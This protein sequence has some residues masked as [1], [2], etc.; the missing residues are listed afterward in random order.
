MSSVG[1][2]AVRNKGGRVKGQFR[3]GES[4]EAP[5][6]MPSSVLPASHCAHSQDRA[7]GV[8]ASRAGGVLGRERRAGLRAGVTHPSGRSP[9]SEPT[10]RQARRL[11]LR[12][13]ALLESTA[14]D[15]LETIP[16]SLTSQLGQNTSLPSLRILD[17]LSLLF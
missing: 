13:A 6:K 15:T 5:P 4:R 16:L 8:E 17:P 11:S 10:L 1:S 14:S 3:G 7:T 2:G 12:S 9:A